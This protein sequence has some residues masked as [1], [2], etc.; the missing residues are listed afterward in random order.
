MLAVVEA[1]GP[2]NVAQPLRLIRRVS[3]PGG[4]LRPSSLL[5]S[6]ASRADSYNDMPRGLI[7]RGHAQVD[8]YPA[9]FPASQGRHCARCFGAK[10]YSPVLLC[11]PSNLHDIIYASLRGS[12]RGDRIGKWLPE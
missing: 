3:A 1:G 10:R 6:S 5:E 11:N 7:F 8:L 12:A 9:R 2:S 4:F